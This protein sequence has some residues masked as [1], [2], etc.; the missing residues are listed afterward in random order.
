MVPDSNTSLNTIDMF[1]PNDTQ[2]LLENNDNTISDRT[3]DMFGRSPAKDRTLDMFGRDDTPETMNTSIDIFG[4]NKTIQSPDTT[5]DMFER[6]PKQT[7]MKSPVSELLL[8]LFISP[9]ATSKQ[10]YGSFI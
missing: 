10:G 5:I 2:D 3:I 6:I 7:E 4:N 1:G 9:F 8:L